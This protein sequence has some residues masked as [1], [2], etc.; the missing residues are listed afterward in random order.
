MTY[1]FSFTG[2]DGTDYSL[3]GYKVIYDDPGMDVWGDMTK[4][5][6]RLY[7]G[8][9][10]EGAPVGSG[11]L[12]FKLFDLPSMLSSFEVTNTDSPLTEIRTISAVC[13]IL[14]RCGKGTLSSGLDL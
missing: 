1:S 2:K 9:K 12:R 13:P 4:L 3:Y 5:F 14:L 8:K 6:T 7:R 11:I 10:T